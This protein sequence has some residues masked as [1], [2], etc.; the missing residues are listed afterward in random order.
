MKKCYQS[1]NKNLIAFDASAKIN[2][3]LH[4]TGKKENGYHLLDS[5]FAF[6]DCGDKIVVCSSDNFVFK[7]RGKFAKDLADCSH[8]IVIKAFEEVRRYLPEDAVN[9]ESVEITLFKNLPVASGIGGGS[10]D[11][12]ATIKA[13][14]QFWHLSLSE[15]TLKDIAVKLGADVFPCLEGYAS[16]VSGIGDIVKPYYNMPARIYGVL[17]NPLIA[18]STPSVFKKYQP[19]FSKA[20]PFD[21]KKITKKDFFIGLNQR[22]NDLELAA[23][24]VC[25]EIEKV[26]DSLKNTEGCVLSRMSGSGATCFG[27][28]RTKKEAKA[29]K[30]R[31]S[32]AFNGWWVK[33][34]SISN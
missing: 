34:I 1:Q 29:A 23:I 17:I 22:K 18:V 7:V 27:L 32:K 21:D 25:P 12:A 4:V 9:R 5:L 33:E 26:L 10:A 15:K 11:A 13:L 19:N 16:Q 20:M 8:N 24:E 30:Q 3:Y 6:A 31:I 28:Y 14:C 2:L